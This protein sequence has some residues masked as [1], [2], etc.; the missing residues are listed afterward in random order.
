MQIFFASEYSTDRRKLVFSIVETLVCYVRNFGL[1]QTLAFVGHV[2]L[3]Y[4]VVHQLDSIVH[5]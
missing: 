4:M 2:R 3:T 5:F 1:K